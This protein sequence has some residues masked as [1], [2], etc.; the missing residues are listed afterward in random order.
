M[1]LISKR[2]SIVFIRDVVYDIMD[3]EMM[4][5]MIDVVS[6][7]IS[8]LKVVATIEKS[9]NVQQ[10][11]KLGDENFNKAA[12]SIEEDR[13]SR[14]TERLYS[15]AVERMFLISLKRKYAGKH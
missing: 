13:R 6:F 8:T 5:R 1:P 4:H 9:Y 10:R 2:R 14:T 12:I 7:L 15:L 3:N 11:W